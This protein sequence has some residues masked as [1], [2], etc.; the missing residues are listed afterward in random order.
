MVNGENLRL[1]NTSLLGNECYV[2]YLQKRVIIQQRHSTETKF[3]RE[4]P[5]CWCFISP[6]VGLQLLVHVFG[7]QNVIK[8]VN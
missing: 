7:V 1:V 4:S 2:I 6:D 5:V 3:R 8:C